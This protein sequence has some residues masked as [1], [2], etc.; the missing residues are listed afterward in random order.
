MHLVY[1]LIS[2]IEMQPSTSGEILSK[3]GDIVRENG[4]LEP[5][6]EKDV[7]VV[8]MVDLDNDADSE[9]EGKLFEVKTL[10]R[11]YEYYELNIF[12]LHE[13]VIN[14]YFEV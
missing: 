11:T 10:I 1:K 13:Y 2:V 3:P 9:Y 12:I 14:K 5:S 7:T 6:G 8:A 4:E